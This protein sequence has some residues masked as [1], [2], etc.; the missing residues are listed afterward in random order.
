L[1]LFGHYFW[2]FS[3]TICLYPNYECVFS[4]LVGHHA[5]TV[6]VHRE[7]LRQL[8]HPWHGYGT[9]SPEHRRPCAIHLQ[10]APSVRPLRNE[11]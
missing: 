11:S 7:V 10:G 2:G 4:A 3:G 8:P 1:R 6:T 5:L 9:D